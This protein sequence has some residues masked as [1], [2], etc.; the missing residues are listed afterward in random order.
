MTENWADVVIPGM[1][2]VVVEN[3]CGKFGARL[4]EFNAVPKNVQALVGA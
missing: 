1:D 4:E 2:F 3:T